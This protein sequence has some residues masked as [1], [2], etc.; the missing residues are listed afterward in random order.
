MANLFPPGANTAFRVALAGAL[1][2][3]VGTPALLMIL[4]RSPLGTGEG[5]LVPQ[6]LQFDH[7]HHAGDEGIDCRYCHYEVERSAYAGVPPTSLCMGCHAQVWNRSPQLD[8][9]RESVTRNVPIRWQ[10]VNNLPDFV[11]FDH[12]IHVNKGVGCETCHGR[13]DRMAVV[14][15]AAPLTMQWCLD[16]HR[17]PAP[18]L[19]PRDAVTVMGWR[20]ESDALA[21]GLELQ[22]HHAVEPRIDCW[23][24]H[25]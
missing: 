7:R 10:R 4:V 11:Y 13:V 25:R 18:S 20:P 15:Q 23:T 21:L 17:D 2:G 6:P 12:A 14:A 9:V 24:C 19:R 22:A 5:E 1:G 3:V 8:P 16:C